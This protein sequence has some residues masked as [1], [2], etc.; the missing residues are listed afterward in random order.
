MSFDAWL[1]GIE[2][3]SNQ[4]VLPE[5]V[6]L[7]DRVRMSPG[8]RSAIPLRLAVAVAQMPRPAEI[9]RRSGRARTRARMVRGP[10]RLRA[11]IRQRWRRWRAR[12]VREQAVQDA[13]KW[14][15]R[16]PK[17][18]RIVGLDGLHSVRDGGRGA[19]VVGLRLGPAFAL[20]ELLARR[21][22]RV[23]LVTAKDPRDRGPIAGRRARLKAMWRAR[24][25][26]AGVRFVSRSPA[27]EIAELLRRGMVAF[28]YMDFGGT[29][30]TGL[31]G[32]SF[33]LGAEASELAFVA[34][35]PVFP[36]LIIRR[37]GRLHAE[38]LPRLEPRRDWTPEELHARIAEA[39][40]PALQAHLA[41]LYPYALTT[42]EQAAER[43][44]RARRKRA[45]RAEAL[46]ATAPRE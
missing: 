20:P 41:Q 21:L 28:T 13:L 23:Y 25:E 38:L 29:R 2:E 30:A 12:R 14:R 42:A 35:V 4:H 18:T 7:R 10:H 39:L 6:P 26:R 27:P 15:R 17:R 31:L 8:L 34:D 16:A 11:F 45:R 22:G 5:G 36:A 24:A 3:P 46:T 9:R 43:A 44:K 1:D 32:R 19:L 37:G 33:Q 40:D